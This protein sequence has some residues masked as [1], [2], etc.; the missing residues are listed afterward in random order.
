[1]LC[2][3]ST[4]QADNI[5]VLNGDLPLITADI[6]NTLREEHFKHNAAISII[7]S[8]NI[9]PANAFGRIV[10]QGNHIK[11]VEKKH[12]TYD[13]KD[14]PYVN[15]G[16]YLINRLFLDS[17][18]DQIKQNN[19]SKEF[20][21]TDLVEIASSNSLPVITVPM[22]FEPLNGVNTFQELAYAEKIKH[23]ELINYWMTNGVRFIAP[24]TIHMD[25][26][27]KIA[28]GTVVQAGAQ[29]LN[30]TTIGEFCT[31]GAHA[32]LD[33]A[34]IQDNATIGANSML[35]NFVVSKGQHIKACSH[36]IN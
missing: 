17:F 30:G 12:F 6:I 22:P 20:Y 35:E 32:V 26:N 29:L 10:Q 23:D 8:Y 24:D 3:K 33:N 36:Y 9:D 2:S 34:T 14:H 4:W 18:L 7:T 25:Y 1:L 28:K 5:L 21:I 15:C 13:I 16:V 31:I 19:T 11:I 27:V